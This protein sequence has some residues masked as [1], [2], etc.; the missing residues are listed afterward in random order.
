MTPRLGTPARHAN[1]YSGIDLSPFT[2]SAGLGHFV[3][4]YHEDGFLLDAVG[5]FIGTALAGGDAG[6]V[7][8]TRPHRDRLV[9]ALTARGL[10]VAA[11][12]ACGR[13]IALDAAEVVAHVMEGGWPDEARFAEV[14]EDLLARAATAAANGRVRA[15]GEIVA[16]LCAEGRHEAAIRVEELWNELAKK[17]RFSLFCAY[18][19]GAFRREV[20][21]T[22]FLRICAEHA[23]VIPAESFTALKTP[24]ERLRAVSRLQQQARALETEAGERKKAEQSLHRKHEE[25]SDFLEN[26]VEGLQRVGP[27]GGV[28]WANKALL[29]LLGYTAEEYVGHGAAD[30]HVQREV[31]DE[32]WRRLMRRETLFDYPADLRCKDGS[33]KH[34]L[35]HSNGLWEDGRFLYTRCFIRN[36]TEQRQLQA[37]LERRLEQLAEI[38]RRKDE[39]IAMLGHELR[40][41]LAAVQNAIAAARLD[42]SRRERAL[43]I[44]R[45]QTAQ[46]ERLVDDLLEVPRLTQGRLALR[47]VCVSLA[48]IIARAVDATRWLVEARGHALAVSTP[49]DPVY[50]EGDPARIEQAVA[51]LLTNAANYTEPGGRIQLIAAR[52][53]AEAVLRVRDTG[54]GIAPDML[55]R[56]FDLF[57]Q[58]PQTLDRAQGGLGIGLT[59]VRRVIDLHGG[60]VAAHS[61]GIG[62]GAEFV[63]WLPALCVAERA[64]GGATGL[65]AVGRRARVLVVED[66][67]DAA[68]S[69]GMLIELLGHEV[70]VVHNGPA[71]LDAIRREPPEMALVDI[72]LPGMDGYEV[73]RSIRA[74]PRG[75]ITVLVALTGYGRDEDKQ[76]AR[77]AGFDH[78]LTKPV[79]MDAL[80]DLLGRLQTS[81]LRSDHRSRPH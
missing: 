52:E 49:S 27:D 78:H 67:V 53:G 8:A 56:V 74:C 60:R 50:V 59:V 79:D 43:D 64:T 71:A 33:I 21:G 1:D 29:G 24:V 7:I 47:T 28:R 31:F 4:F 25:L 69:L 14:V 46:L 37:E 54:I 26:A 18:P 19:I 58:G 35:I 73:A 9:E 62:K 45:R 48:D 66:N 39:F 6:V 77:A 51:N 40:N 15:F 16:L 13:Y 23:H 20:D 44:A 3:Q 70:R 68:E 80:R 17:R 55:P 5:R 38:D 10:D 36:V 12:G 63:V 61:D 72:G 11:A 41:P 57:A 30:F 42:A 65:P 22:P 34:V 81:H 2:S 32:L 75:A 76:Q